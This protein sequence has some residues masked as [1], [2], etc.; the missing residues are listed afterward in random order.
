MALTTGCPSAQKSSETADT[1][2]SVSPENKVTDPSVTPAIVDT[3]T[4]ENQTPIDPNSKDKKEG[5]SVD[6]KIVGGILVGGTLLAALLAHKM[7][8]VKAV[9]IQDIDKKPIA[10]L[11]P[12]ADTL[13]DVENIFFHIR[14]ATPSQSEIDNIVYKIR[15][16]PAN[17][18][19]LQ[20][21]SMDDKRRRVVSQDYFMLNDI[22]LQKYRKNPLTDKKEIADYIFSF[23]SCMAEFIK[24]IYAITKNPEVKKSPELLNIVKEDFRLKREKLIKE[25]INL[26]G[27]EP[28]WLTTPK[29]G[30]LD[31]LGLLY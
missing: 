22:E 3:K 25:A 14:T 16:F 29:T 28:K 26:A 23:N 11:S 19:N 18:M 30:L 27:Y 20:N 2:K 8:K 4:L 17:K 10:L 1:P 9:D 15:K 21:L 13:Q 12:G 24:D 7:N 6:P 31:Q 5:N